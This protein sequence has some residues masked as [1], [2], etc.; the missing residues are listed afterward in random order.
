MIQSFPLF[1]VFFS[2]GLPAT[3]DIFIAKHSVLFFLAISFSDRRRNFTC[4]SKDKKKGQED[5]RKTVKGSASS[6]IFLSIISERKPLVHLI[7]DFVIM[8]GLV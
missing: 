6:S 5:Q 7:C 3:L 8:L 4:A 1:H 2:P